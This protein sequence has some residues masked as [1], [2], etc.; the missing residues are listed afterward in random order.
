M[1]TP[2][3][4]RVLQG[5]FNL[6][7]AEQDEV[8]QEVIKYQRATATQKPQISEEY[9]AKGRVHL[10]PTQTTCVCCGK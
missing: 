1:V 9:R 6:S 2:N 8:I 3:A 5:F 7:Q 4:K 10:G